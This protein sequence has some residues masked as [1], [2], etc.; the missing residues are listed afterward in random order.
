MAKT[1]VGLYATFDVVRDVI[2]DL[3]DNGIRRDDISLV[4]DNT[5][6][7]FEQYTREAHASLGAIADMVPGMGVID[8]QD[9]GIVL[10][11]GPMVGVLSDVAAGGF[12]GALVSMGVPERDAERYTQGVFQGA[13]LLTIYCSEGMVD[14]VAGIVSRH[15][16]IDVHTDVHSREDIRNVPAETG[17]DRGSTP[18]VT[19]DLDQDHTLG[20]P[21]RPTG[22]QDSQA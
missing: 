18:Y 11:T 2:H 7:Q 3:E 5:R 4:A 16:P 17:F 14:R 6:G 19:E 1:I 10:A 8:T 20:L 21:V 15:H 13:V 22:E 9:L 12:K